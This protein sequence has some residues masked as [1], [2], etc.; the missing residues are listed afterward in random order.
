MLALGPEARSVP[1]D[2]KPRPSAG[3]AVVFVWYRMVWIV[4]GGVPR[5]VDGVDAAVPRRR[6]RDAVG[7]MKAERRAVG[8]S[9]NGARRPVAP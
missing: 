7:S 1:H 3:A 5:R 6:R 2:G 8:A 4:P 9:A